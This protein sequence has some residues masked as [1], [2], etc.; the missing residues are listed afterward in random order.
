L[1]FAALDILKQ[2]V[3]QKDSSCF[4]LV[5]FLS[6]FLQLDQPK[7]K[8]HGGSDPPAK[9]VVSVGSEKK[10]SVRDG[11]ETSALRQWH[12]LLAVVDIHHVV[13]EC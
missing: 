5:G 8:S 7:D 10:T 13:R 1:G 3:G 12:K 6:G 9:V 11:K 4:L 2:Q